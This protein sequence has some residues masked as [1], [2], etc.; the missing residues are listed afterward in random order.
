MHGLQN[1]IGWILMQIKWI[2][3]WH[4]DPNVGSSGYAFG[5]Q[6]SCVQMRI[7]TLIHVSQ[8]NSTLN[9]IFEG[10][11]LG[12]KIMFESYRKLNYF[13]DETKTIHLELY[14]KNYD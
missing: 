6:A 11:E 5:P 3:F 2:H 13:S 9:S 1:Q 4:P 14:I 12:K 10:L 8:Q 7:K